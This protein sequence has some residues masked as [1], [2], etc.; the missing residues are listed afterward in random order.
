MIKLIRTDYTNPDFINLVK[1]LDDELR[2]NDGDAHPFYA[3]YNKIENINNVVVGYFDDTPAACGAIK[4]YTDDIAEVKRMFVI[5]GFRGKGISKSVLKELE[6]WA[7]ELNYS[8]CILE[9][10]RKQTTAITLYQSN[11]YDLIPNYGQY[12]G[13]ELSVC[14]KKII[15]LNNEINKSQTT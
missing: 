3:Q 10:G 12:E 14:M 13:K 6:S 2:E 15:N 1:L 7:D 9:T 4:K 8:E 11:G 5:P